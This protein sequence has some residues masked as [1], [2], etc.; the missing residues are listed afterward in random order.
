MPMIRKLYVLHEEFQNIDKRART[1][2]LKDVPDV[3]EAG[4]LFV[5]EVVVPQ[6]GRQKA[7]DALQYCDDEG[8]PM[9]AFERGTPMYTKLM[10]VLRRAQPGAIRLIHEYNAYTPDCVL[11]VLKRLADSGVVSLQ[12]LEAAIIAHRRS[13]DYDMLDED[14]TVMVPKAGHSKLDPDEGL[15]DPTRNDYDPDLDG[16][17]DAAAIAEGEDGDG[18]DDGGDE[19]DDDGDGEG[20]DGEGEDG[21]D[22]GD[23]DGDE[24][25]AVAVESV[26]EDYVEAVAAVLQEKLGREVII[27]NRPL[28]KAFK[29]G[30]DPTAFANK[31]IKAKKLKPET[32][33]K[34]EPKDDLTDKILILAERV[35]QALCQTPGKARK[36]QMLAE[37]TDA[38]AKDVFLAMDHLAS[39]GRI[40]AKGRAVIPGKK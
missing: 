9:V 8:M 31:L 13:H 11:D 4:D 24:E 5:H 36:L 15:T 25:A 6:N 26:F 14:D 30:E 12:A 40:D 39:Q 17:D 34:T 33:P 32:K 28:A 19:G 20:E 2:P 16:Y 35:Y 1:G 27:A 18:D 3:F 22:D 7:Y 23:E 38:D 29:D 21:D 37:M 10:L